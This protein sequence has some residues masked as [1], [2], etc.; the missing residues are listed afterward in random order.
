MR[1]ILCW[2]WVD[3]KQKRENS[4]NQNK[5]VAFIS[6]TR[7]ERTSQ[8]TIWEGATL[9]WTTLRR[10]D[11]LG[12]NFG[13]EPFT[14]QQRRTCSVNPLHHAQERIHP[15]STRDASSARWTITWAKG[16][17]RASRLTLLGLASR[18]R[19]R[20]WA[21]VWHRRLWGNSHAYEGLYACQPRDRLALLKL[22]T[23]HLNSEAVRVRRL[24]R[25][26]VVNW[27]PVHRGG[28]IIVITQV[29]EA[30]SYRGWCRGWW[31]AD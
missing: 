24:V 23:D 12:N 15:R 14:Q 27:R 1:A 8:W 10:S 20:D 21:A 17:A 25:E 5:Q 30:A 13:K 31:V 29:H 18:R 6:M 2:C 26:W 28:E 22:L 16:P 19:S 11:S 3:W 9:N 7:K 4:E